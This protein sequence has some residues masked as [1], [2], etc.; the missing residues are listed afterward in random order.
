MSPFQHQETI[1]QEKETE[2]NTRKFVTLASV[3]TVLLAPAAFYAATGAQRSSGFAEP[4]TMAT[5]FL[6][7]P[8][9][10][11]AIGLGEPDTMATE[12]VWTPKEPDT[13]ATEFLWIPKHA[14]PAA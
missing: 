2:M 14:Q 3:V 11:Q 10:V 7:I 9:H 4:D 13:M 5:E 8:N 6:W 1:R 12:F